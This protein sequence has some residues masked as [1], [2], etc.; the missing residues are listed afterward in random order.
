MTNTTTQVKEVCEKYKLPQRH[1]DF[2][3]EHFIIG[4]EV[5]VYGKIWQ[6]LRELNQR[7][8]TLEAVDSELL[9]LADNLEWE[10]IALRKL[11]LKKENLNSLSVVISNQESHLLKIKKQEILIRKQK[12]KVLNVEKN[13]AKTQSRKEDVL[14]EC[15]KFIDLFNGLINQTEFVDINDPQAQLEFWT[16][17]FNHEVSLTAALNHPMN[18]EL[19]K[20][21]LALPDESKIK[22][23]MLNALDNVGKKLQT[24]NN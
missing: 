15:G 10:K 22:I 6:C 19:V 2:Q 9:E 14:A 13:I 21:V 1:T 16:T 20:S 18:A 3:I 17:K 11:E 8:E 23:Q 4:K 12:R 24:K 5:S 7:N